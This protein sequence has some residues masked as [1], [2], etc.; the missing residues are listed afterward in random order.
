MMAEPPLTPEIEKVLSRYLEIQAEMHRLS[1]EKGR[2]RDTLLAHVADARGRFWFPVVGGQKLMVAV[3]RKVEID[4]DE[5]V[6]RRRLG[7]RYVQI[8]KP[9]TR[10]MRKRLD[11]IEDTLAPV[12]ALIGSPHP[13]K[14]RAAVESGAVSTEEFQ[15]AFTKRLKESLTVRRARDDD[16]ARP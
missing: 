8:L 12:L 11:D 15:G 9:D 4:Y 14:V 7:D 1:E 13:D 3:R 16:E 5:D 6:L 10:K 2:L